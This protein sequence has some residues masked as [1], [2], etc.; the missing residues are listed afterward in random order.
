MR[1]LS[2]LCCAR[3]CRPRRLRSPVVGQRPDDQIAPQSVELHAAGRGA[4]RA[5]ASSIEA[6]DALE[7]ALAV[8][9]RNRCGVRRSWPGWREAAAVRQGDPPDQQGAGARAERPRRARGPGRGDGRAGRACR[10]RRTTSQKLQKLCAP[11]GCPQVAQLS[12]AISARADGRGGQGARQS[13]RRTRLSSARQRDEFV[14]AERFGAPLRVDSELC[15]RRR[16]R[17]A[18]PSGSSAAS[19]G[20]GRRRPRSAVPGPSGSTPA[21]CFGRDDVHDR[22]RHLG[23]RHEGRAVDASSRSAASRAT[24]RRPTAGRNARCRACA[25]IRSATSF[26]NI[27]VSDRHHGG[28]GPLEPAQ[29]QRGADIVGQVGDDMGAVAGLG[30]LVDLAARRPR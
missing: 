23:R 9:P 15:Q 1:S 11:S 4:A 10:A 30:A 12:A 6:D 3:P 17:R 28:H 18:C 29:Q 20:A 16:A 26:W 19:C 5:Q 7:T 8:D 22:R 25:T 21:G 14:D 24:A 2:R 27:R 13:R